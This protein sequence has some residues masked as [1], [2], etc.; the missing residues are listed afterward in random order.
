VLNRASRVH[1][2]A[3]VILGGAVLVGSLLLGACDNSSRGA[4]GTASSL[5]GTAT[6]TSRTSTGEG[7][8]STRTTTIGHKSAEA[9]SKTAQ[10]PTSPVN[11]QTL[12]AFEA[13]LG[14]LGQSLSQAVSGV[15]KTQGDS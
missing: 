8:G 10:A 7:L 2:V 11:Q 15:D 1:P 3:A 13:Q 6:T 9:T 5:S 14:A 4:S 12:S